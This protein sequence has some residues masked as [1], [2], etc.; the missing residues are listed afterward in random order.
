MGAFNSSKEC[1]QY[2]RIIFQS[3]MFKVLQD[4]F[5]RLEVWICFFAYGYGYRSNRLIQLHSRNRPLIK[6]DGG[7]G[8]WGYDLPKIESL[9]G[10]QNFLLE[11]GDK[12]EKGG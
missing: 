6:R 9:G 1:L 8:G 4:V 10:V 12:P 5:E 11:R 3:L 2:S 7:E